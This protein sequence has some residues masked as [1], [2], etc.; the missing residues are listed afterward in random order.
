MCALETLRDVLGAKAGEQ[1]GSRAAFSCRLCCDVRGVGDTRSA[2]SWT[3]SPWRSVQD[4][5]PKR[6][7]CPFF[8]LCLP[9]AITSLCA[10]G[11]MTERT[12]TDSRYWHCPYR[13]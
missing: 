10:E 5:W 11:V 2:E 3:D 7:I 1:S 12:I 9:L 13:P 8:P 4:I 6:F